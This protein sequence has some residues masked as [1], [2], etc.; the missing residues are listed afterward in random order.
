MKLHID[1]ETF[2]DVDLKT[3][4]IARYV[5][6]DYF[7][8]L[9]FGYAFDNEPIKYIDLDNGGKIP[10]SIANAIFN[11]AVTKKAWN[12]E[13]EI[14][15]L[16]QYFSKKIDIRQWEC[17]MIGATMLGL[18]AS[19]AQAGLALDL[20]TTKDTAGK[21]LIRLFCKPN[22]KKGATLFEVRN[23]KETHPEK[24]AAF[25]EYLKG[26]V[27]QER[28]IDEKI[29]PLIKKV[30]TQNEKIIWFVNDLINRRGV[31]VDIEFVRKCIELSE[32][33][34][35]N[36]LKEAIQLTKL[37]NPNSRNQI[38]AWL[39]SAIGESIES[40]NKKYIPGIA[41]KAMDKTTERV[42]ELRQELSKSSVK[43]YSAIINAVCENGRV[44]GLHRYFGAP[45]TGRFS[46]SLVQI[47]NLKRNELANLAAAR[48]T[49]QK[50][51]LAELGAFFIENPQEIL[52]QLIRTAFIAK[53]GHSLVMSDFSAIEARVTAWLAGEK[54][55][56]DI[57][58]THGKIYEASAAKMFKV[59]IEQV[60]KGSEY[61]AKGKIS[62]LALGFQGGVEALKRMG[63]ED[64]GLSEPE[65]KNIV[66]MWRKENPKIVK[67][68]KEIEECAIKAI[69]LKG[70]VINHSSNVSFHVKDD[71]LWLQL[72]SGRFITY[73]K[74]R[75]KTIFVEAWDAEKEVITYVGMEQ[76]RQQLSVLTT[77][78]GKLTENIVQG[79]ARDLLAEAM[80]RLTREKFEIVLHVHDEV[81]SEVPDSV[82]AS[83]V[84]K[85]NKIMASQP[86]WAKGLP[87]TADT[88]VSKYYKK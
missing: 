20:D 70:K 81:V 83:S 51:G 38:K 54:W 43:K 23:T 52:S 21:A 65:M 73:K 40:L 3:S 34:K 14:A 28:L 48:I 10:A 57:F 22:T 45:K 11:P 42:I 17:T 41:A 56:M 7:K 61:R 26:D 30:F 27:R 15:C 39:E 35:T 55:R 74:P 4:G 59:P 8:I 5:E 49:V 36:C 88:T 68:W 6:S 87:L 72:P 2:C 71:I 79:I 58:N 69:R 53:D 16:E 67:Y 33:Q 76:V 66:Q 24:W 1:L 46:S 18:P 44:K 63:G 60:T 37:A 25:I 64:M 78:G 19:L 82:L 50:Y 47:H 32:K 84:I 77:Y 86:I 75:I 12:A 9:L 13:F 80:I 29:S 62:E 85:I 31:K